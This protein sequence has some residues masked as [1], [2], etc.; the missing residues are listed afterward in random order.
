MLEACDLSI[1]HGM[2][3]YSAGP[4]SFS[5]TSRSARKTI[6][7]HPLILSVGIN[8]FDVGIHWVNIEK[9]N[10]NGFNYT[11]RRGYSV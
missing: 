1:F 9:C 3:G 6:F 8:T 10:A 2:F 5:Y 11:I 4:L 7:P